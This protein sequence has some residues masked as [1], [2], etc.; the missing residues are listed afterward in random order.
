[1]GANVS[2]RKETKCLVVVEATVVAQVTRFL[3]K[4]CISCAYMKVDCINDAFL[5]V[6]LVSAPVLAHIILT[7]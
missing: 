1:M 7:K 3:H 6:D 5:Y 2:E 4:L